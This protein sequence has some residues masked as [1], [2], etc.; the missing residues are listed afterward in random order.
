MC[1]CESVRA[2][3]QLVLVKRALD[4]MQTE[5]NPVTDLWRRIAGI[6]NDAGACADLCVLACLMNC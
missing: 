4:G 3:L 5:E 1:E 2:S 6:R